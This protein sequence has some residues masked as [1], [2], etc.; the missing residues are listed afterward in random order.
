VR[1]ALF[2][3]TALALLLRGGALLR[4]TALFSPG[5][6]M[7]FVSRYQP[8]LA[9]KLFLVAGFLGGVSTRFERY[10]G[11]LPPGCLIVSN[12]QSLADIPALAVTFSDRG[13][14]YVAKKS[15]GRG[16]PYVSPSLRMGRHAL[17][18]RTGE[19]RES[20]EAMRQLAELSRD[21]ICPVVFPEGTRSRDGSVKGFYAGALRVMLEHQSMP[22]LSV[23]VD[24][25][26]RIATVPR[27]ILHSRGACYRVRPLT[28]YPAPR[29]K[30]EIAELTQK[31]EREISA[32]VAAWRRQDRGA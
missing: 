19:Y 11:S 20:Q 8:V 9:R 28:L 18:S 2:L 12:H 6:V 32:Q 29:G 10:R 24:G 16:L 1:S 5:A 26:Y 3:L 7:H 4:L 31:M 14:R 25:G 17:I 27:L 21:G 30:R 23:A 13:L 15:L 22:V